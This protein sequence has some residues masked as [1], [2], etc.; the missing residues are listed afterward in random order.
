MSN[1]HHR[2]QWTPADADGRCFPGQTCRSPGS[3]HRDLASGRR[4]QQH[5]RIRPWLCIKAA[6]LRAAAGPASAPGSALGG[7]P[8]AR[9]ATAA[10]GTQIDVAQTS[11]KPVQRESVPL[12]PGYPARRPPRQRRRYTRRCAIGCAWPLTR[13]MLAPGPHIPEPPVTSPRRYPLVM[14]PA[15]PP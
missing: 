15:V 9:R 8:G 11:G 4:G 1:N 3:P 7:P 14:Q 2:Q 6:P 5:C 10:R 13:Q 12:A